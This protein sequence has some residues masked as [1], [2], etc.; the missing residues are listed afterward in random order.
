MYITTDVT[1]NPAAAEIADR[2]VL[3]TDRKQSGM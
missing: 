2:T 1:R 3:E